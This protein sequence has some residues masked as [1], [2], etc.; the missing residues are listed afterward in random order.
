MKTNARQEPDNMKKKTMLL[1]AGAALI[2]LLGVLLLKKPGGEYY[3]L[4]KTDID[5]KILASCTVSFPEPYEMAA[6]A[7]GDVVRIAVVEG[8]QVKK[9][10][11]LVQ[12]DDFKEKQNLAIAASNYENVKL[13]LVNAREEVYP[14]LKE[15][16]NDAG[17]ALA[18]AQ[19]HADRIDALYSA[20]A[21]SKVEWE[22]AKTTLD[23]AQARFNQVKLQVD[24]YSR[25]GAAAELI[26][27]LNILNAQVELARRAVGDKRFMAPY[28]CTIVKLDVKQGETVASG[29]KV[30]TILEKKP[31][32]LE[33]NVDQKE[34]GFLEAGLPCAVIFDAYPAEKVKAGISLVCSVIDF[35]KGTC[36]LKLQVMESRPFIKHGMTGSVEIAGKKTAGVNA[37]VLALPAK[38]VLRE[39]GGDF[40]L[41]RKGGESVKTALEF[42]PI[43]E[44]WVSVTNLPAGTRIVLPE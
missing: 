17:A 44:T 42:T 41:V 23:A 9:G 37:G 13:K 4:R 40:V 26:N 27:Q 32:V 6:R 1:L 11:L 2:A 15:Q 33:T 34:L 36:N 30:L 19:N 21:V 12:V 25:S 3:T 7:E 20:G 43:G 5:Y 14:R 29:K 16:L 22:R 35:A 10:D 39:K 8:Q 28:D 38:Y 24:S 31:W 18:D